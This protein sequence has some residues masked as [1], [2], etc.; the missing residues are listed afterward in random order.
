MPYPCDQ[1]QS[2]SI[3]GINTHEHGCPDS[4]KD[5]SYPCFIC[6]YDFMRSDPHQITC[7]DCLQDSD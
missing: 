7:P 1:C 5:K 6:G 2:N 4:W 3:N